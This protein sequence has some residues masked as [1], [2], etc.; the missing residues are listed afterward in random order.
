MTTLE[1][2]LRSALRTQA[3]ALRVPE[4]P[5][6]DREAVESH[7]PRG[8]RWL[9]AAACVALVVAGVVALTVRNAGD[10]EPAPPVAPVVRDTTTTTT[11][12]TTSST[13]TSTTTTSGT[14]PADAV[15]ELLNGFIE[16][17]L[18]GVGAEQYLPDENVPL[19]YSTSSGA[20]YERAEFERVPGE[21]PHEW[22]AF[23]VRLFAGDTVVEQLFFTTGTGPLW[24]EYQQD[25][26]GTDIAPT[27]E[28]GEPVA[29]PYDFFDGQVTVQFAHP[30]IVS[31]PRPFA[32]VVPEG[33]GP[34]PTTDGGQRIDWD[35]LVLIADPAATAAMGC[36]PGTSAS[37]ASTLAETIRSAPD[38]GATAPVAVNLGGVDALMMDVVIPA[39]T[40]L[41]APESGMA[42]LMHPIFDVHAPA[43]TDGNGI[44]TGRA[45]GESMRLYLFDAPEGSSMRILAIAIV[46]PASRLERAAEEAAPVLDSVEFNV[47]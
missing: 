33:P 18:A 21:W 36:E 45:T 23:K 26:F 7:G 5:A 39:G 28:D 15:T 11:S 41:C 8:P 3:Q 19:L 24:L 46:A 35:E 29:L 42:D 27:T 40:I 47:P 2:Q 30:W 9:L 44:W 31:W 20:R 17:R 6:L 10:P 14:A 32:R 43:S 22:T 16:A 13:T 1:D 37:D 12:T 4:R 38:L 34:A 25:S